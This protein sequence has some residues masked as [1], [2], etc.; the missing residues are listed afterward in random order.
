MDQ[1][2]ED[3][4]YG[5]DSVLTDSI[6]TSELH[7]SFDETDTMPALVSRFTLLG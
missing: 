4:K 3:F 1:A 2:I 7:A 5:L 6:D